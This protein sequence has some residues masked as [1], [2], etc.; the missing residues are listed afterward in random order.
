MGFP[1]LYLYL[2][3]PGVP[4]ITGIALFF[5]F[6]AHCTVIVKSLYFKIFSASLFCAQLYVYCGFHNE[7]TI[8]PIQHETLGTALPQCRAGISLLSSERFLYI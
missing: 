4:I 5:T 3:L 7:W 8:F 6:H 1:Y 2:Y